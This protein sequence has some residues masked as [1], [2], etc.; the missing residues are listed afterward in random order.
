MVQVGA[1]RPWIKREQMG[2]QEFV[3][4]RARDGRMIPAYFTLPACKSSD[5]K[6]GNG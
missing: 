1:E 4:Y 3:R 2:T 6:T 5:L